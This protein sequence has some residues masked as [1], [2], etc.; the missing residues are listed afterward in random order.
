MYVSALVVLEKLAL[1][2][3][4]G[5]IPLQKH[6]TF[7]SLMSQIWYCVHTI[8]A[9]EDVKSYYRELL[10][11]WPKITETPER[12]SSARKLIHREINYEYQ[13]LADKTF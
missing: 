13:I 8:W 12:V 6:D 5:L 11:I 7:N 9:L 10:E 4:H 1:D 3:L 2:S